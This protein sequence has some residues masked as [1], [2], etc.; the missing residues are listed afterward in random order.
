MYGQERRTAG[1]VILRKFSKLSSR[2]AHVHIQNQNNNCIMYESSL[3]NINAVAFDRVIFA[4]NH[5]E[6]GEKF[7][8]NTVC[9]RF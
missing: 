7:Y 1:K 4:L 9:Y 5:I 3:K 2:Y 6:I 8:I